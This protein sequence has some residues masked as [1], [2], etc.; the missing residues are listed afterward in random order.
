[1]L[2][3]L[4]RGLDERLDT[5]VVSHGDADHA[6]GA[7][8]VLA[9]QPQAVLRAALAPTH[10]LQAAHPVP[11]A[12]GQRWEWDG[13]AFELLHPLDPAAPVRKANAQS[14]VLRV[15]AA[16]GH[17]AL[18]A[19]D[20]EQ[21]QEAQLLANGADLRADVLLVPHHGSKTS[22][23]AAFLAAVAPRFAVVQ[24]G[25]RNRFGH[26]A[27]EVVARLQAQ[28]STVVDTTRCGAAQWRS[29]M[30]AAVVCERDDRSRYWQHRVP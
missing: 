29:D 18:L 25:Y 5:V 30:P 2:V 24:A 15:R 22:S 16:D 28:G 10:A 19:G 13:V 14:C 1:M 6:G 21:P 8:A 20:I 4:L 26:P 23:S 11:C 12:A 7:E 9:M 3:P 27:P 17:G